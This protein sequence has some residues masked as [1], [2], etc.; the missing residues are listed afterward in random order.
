M[1]PY[2]RHPKQ[3]VSSLSLACVLN[4]VLTLAVGCGDAKEVVCFDNAECGYGMTCLAE[5][6]IDASCDEGDALSLPCGEDLT[7]VTTATCV[8]DVWEVSE[9]CEPLETCSDG[10]LR[11]IACGVSNQGI[12]LQVCIAGEWKA[13]GMCFDVNEL[14][15]PDSQV[16]IPGVEQFNSELGINPGKLPLINN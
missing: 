15:L 5:Q 9:T 14:V 8:N 6:C 11:K 4:I 16:S 1:N 7:G 2:Y 12:Q 3:T 10:E 13:D